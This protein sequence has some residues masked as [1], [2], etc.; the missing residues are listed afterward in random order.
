MQW[1]IQVCIFRLPSFFSS[2]RLWRPFDLCDLRIL[3]R[4]HQSN[5]NQVITVIISLFC[6]LLLLSIPATIGA[7][8]ATESPLYKMK[9]LRRKI[10]R[11]QAKQIKKINKTANESVKK[12]R[13]KSLNK[14]DPCS[15]TH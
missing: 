13:T 6:I 8:N 5:Y 14:G 15:G 9:L 3:A 1:C 7:R 11:L 12:C 10:K 2:N 4:F